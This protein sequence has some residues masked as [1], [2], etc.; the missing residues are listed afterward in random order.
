MTR[1]GSAVSACEGGNR[2]NPYRAYVAW[3]PDEF[4]I[5]HVNSNYHTLDELI[6]VFNSVMR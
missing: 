1:D 2:W 6:P 5:V 4:T 3:H